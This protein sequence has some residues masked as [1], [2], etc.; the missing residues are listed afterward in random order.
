MNWMARRPLDMSICPHAVR[1]RHL[2]VVDGAQV[3]ERQDDAHRALVVVAVELLG[4]LFGAAVAYR[5]VGDALV[6][7][8]RAE[9]EL[10]CPRPAH[11]RQRG[12]VADHCRHA[13]VPEGRRGAPR[14]G[15]E[16]Q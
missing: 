15:A 6:E 1:P 11:Q 2:L 10:D 14:K 3:R 9:R 8:R 4:E 12:D 7:V 13:R 16:D 5:R